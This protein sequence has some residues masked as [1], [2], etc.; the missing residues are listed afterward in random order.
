MLVPS[1]AV[2]R[3]ARRLPSVDVTAVVRSKFQQLAF[4]HAAMLGGEAAMVVALADSFFFDV[5]PSGAR[6]KVLGFLLV[7]FAPFLLIA[8]L[9][10]PAIDRVRGGRRLI[11]QGV[12]A[13][14]IVIQVLMVQFADDILLF[15]LVFVALVLQK[16]YTVS[17]SALVPAVVRSERELVEANSKLGV[18]AG[19]SGAV[20]VVPAAV[21]QV[22]VGTSATLLYGA[23]VF[24][25]ALAMALALP[26]ELRVTPDTPS[27]AT[28]DATTTALQLAWVAMLI[29]RAAA[30]FMLFHLAF[31]F[32]GQ[33]DEKT[34]IGA[35]V[36]LSSLG[37]MVG[38]SVA[39]RLR[40]TLHEERMITVALALPAVAGLVAAGIGG[41]PMG[42]AVAVVVNFS[43]AIGRLSFESIVQRDGPATNRGQAFARFETRFQLGWVVAAVLPVLIEMPSSVGYLLVGAVTAAAVVNYRAGLAAGSAPI[44]RR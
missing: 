8:P 22:T 12:A 43:A 39:P 14:R 24:G 19:I 31:T 26:Q 32:R 38:N 33:P 6:S 5:D 23:G 34:L 16:T 36:A 11:I 17:K 15:P 10:G 2:A 18:I 25:L 35:A 29:L 42:I 1:V 21:L 40:R 37:T 28:P 3:G 44:I 13:T 9:I 30:G 7:S 4:T 41:A 20:A 27:A